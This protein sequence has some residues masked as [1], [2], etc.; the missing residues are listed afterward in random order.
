MRKMGKKSRGSR[1]KKKLRASELERRRKMA[2]KEAA[3][4]E[5]AAR[6]AAYEDHNKWLQSLYNQSARTR[7]ALVPMP[8]LL[9]RSGAGS[10]SQVT[11]I[12]RPS[13]RRSRSHRCR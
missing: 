10:S 8:P 2:I 5:A 7:S 11:F 13:R 3:A 6:Q 9:R 1:K 4:K 12:G